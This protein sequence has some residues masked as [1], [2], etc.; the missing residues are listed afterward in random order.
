MW[1]YS[2]IITLKSREKDNLA[3]ETDLSEESLNMR[4]TREERSKLGRSLNANLD[5]SDFI[6]NHTWVSRELALYIFLLLLFLFVLYLLVFRTITFVVLVV[7][8]TD[9]WIQMLVWN[10][11]WLFVEKKGLTDYH[12]SI[13]LSNESQV[14]VIWENSGHFLMSR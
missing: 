8:K 3:T 6:L 9:Q 7:G 5:G 12:I 2:G 11:E 1:L 14:N 4:I 10:F 13:R